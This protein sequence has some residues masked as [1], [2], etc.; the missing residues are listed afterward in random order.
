MIFATFHLRRPSSRYC[1]SRALS[2]DVPERPYVYWAS[3]CLT[4]MAMEAAARLQ[5]KL[6]NTRT[7]IRTADIGTLVPVAES[8]NISSCDVAWLRDAF[9]TSPLFKLLFSSCIDMCRSMAV[10]AVVASGCS[11]A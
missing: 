2:R 1:R 5:T 6:A 4:R 11:N 3:H 10:W 7:F 8:A 9:A